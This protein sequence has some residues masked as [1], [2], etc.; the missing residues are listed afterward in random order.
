MPMSDASSQDA[1]SPLIIRPNMLLVVLAILVIIATAATSLEEGD[2]VASGSSV[3]HDRMFIEALMNATDTVPRDSA[4]VVS[5]N[6]PYVTFFTHH[7]TKVPFGVTS[8]EE[9]VQYM[10]DRNY[11]YLLVFGE[12]SQVPALTTLFTPLGLE[13]LKS[14]FAEISSY[15]TDFGGIHLFKLSPTDNYSEQQPDGWIEY[16]VGQTGIKDFGTPDV[17]VI[18]TIQIRIRDDGSEP[19]NMW[20][21]HISTID[22]QSSKEMTIADFRSGHGFVKQSSAGQQADDIVDPMNSTR[23]LKLTTDGDGLGV[24][25]RKIKISPAIDLT[26]KDLKILFKTDDISRLIEFRVTVTSDGFVNY[27][28]Y[29]IVA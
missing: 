19:V 29:W 1:K 9:L 20:L 27:R 18:D 21:S 3:I 8:K 4:I 11:T 23:F 6:S 28:N 7:P 13:Y 15:S 12:N 17:S 24:F 14:D 26:A 10:L 5:T 2:N 16:A 22:R 25:T